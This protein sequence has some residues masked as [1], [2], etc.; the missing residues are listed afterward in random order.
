MCLACVH[1]D[2]VLSRAKLDCIAM[3]QVWILFFGPVVH[4]ISIHLDMLQDPGWMMLQWPPHVQTYMWKQFSKSVSL[5]VITFFWS[6]INLCSVAVWFPPNFNV[7][8]CL[9]Q[10]QVTNEQRFQEKKNLFT[11]NSQV[12]EVF[13]LSGFAVSLIQDLHPMLYLMFRF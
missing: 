11:I 7:K 1:L 6:Q 12:F 3:P 2:K 10:K 9:Y 8:T 5:R 13:C 4:L